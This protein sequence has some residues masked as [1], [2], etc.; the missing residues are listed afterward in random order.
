MVLKLQEALFPANQID[1]VDKCAEK[2]QNFHSNCY[3]SFK[4]S[5]N[6][7]GKSGHEYQTRK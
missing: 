1:Q 4:G 3:K 6:Y 2:K 7:Q 5:E